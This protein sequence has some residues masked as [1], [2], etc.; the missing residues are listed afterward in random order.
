MQE[1]EGRPSTGPA[2]RLLEEGRRWRGLLG[3]RGMNRAS[4]A[5]RASLSEVGRA[6]AEQRPVQAGDSIESS[7]DQSCRGTGEPVNVLVL[8]VTLEGKI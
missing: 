1:E 4:R 2:G 3:S 6:S 5:S 8:C 7:E